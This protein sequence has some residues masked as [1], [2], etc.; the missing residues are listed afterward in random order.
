MAGAGKKP[1]SARGNVSAGKRAPPRSKQSEE[2]LK[3]TAASSTRISKALQQR[4]LDLF[5]DVAKPTVEDEATLQEV[6]GHL[7]NRD[8]ANAFGKDEYLR[9]Y[10]SRWSP[11][12]A[13]AYLE[14]FENS[15]ELSG[16]HHLDDDGTAPKVMCLGGG[17]G[18]EL[19]A[20]AGWLSMRTDTSPMKARDQLDITLVDIADWTQVVTSLHNAIT[21]PRELSKYASQ[22]K[23]DANRALL[24]PGSID[25]AFDQAD[26]LELAETSVAKVVTRADLITIMFTLN[27]LY[28]ISIARTQKLLSI[29]LGTM[30]KGAHLLIVDSPG[31]Y[32]AVSINGTEKQYPMKWLLDYTLL[33]DPKAP[34]AEGKWELIISDDSRWFRMPES[35]QYPIELENMRYQIHLYKKIR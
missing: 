19:V 6:K 34:K 21:N 20:L 25:V 30:Q 35:L 1:S 24:D 16:W 23:K 18:S 26:V 11:G 27:E 33:G 17:A 2:I 15:F 7:Y 28:S 5:R 10:A 12:R 4:C 8:F 32:S 3:G 31:S 29:D 13:L 22:A 14:I 9:V